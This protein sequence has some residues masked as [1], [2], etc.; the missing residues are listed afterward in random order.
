MI[1]SAKSLIRHSPLG[2]PVSRILFKLR[3]ARELV[4]WLARGRPVPPPH[5]VKRNVVIRY[6]RK[7]SAR[8]LIETGTF[9][10]EMVEAC[11]HRFDRIYSI[12]LDSSLANAAT[13]RF[14]ESEHISIVEGD[15]AH[16][17][18]DILETV[19]EPAVFWLDAHYS[20]GN[21]SIG[22]SWSPV[23]RELEVILSHPVRDHIVLIDD[24]RGFVGTDAE[25]T[26]EEL[27]ELV[28]RERPDWRFDVKNDIIR[29]H[30]DRLSGVGI[31]KH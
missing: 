23:L 21:T 4:A 2:R 5:L 7:Y 3:Q 28:A 24:A 25:T 15:S 22:E 29:A 9:T 6:G 13:S 18:S 12:E 31:P 14:E 17:L 27:R 26:I 10:G 1:G 11:K 20:G 8:V 30:G 16:I 19:L